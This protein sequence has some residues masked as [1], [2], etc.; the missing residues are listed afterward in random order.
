MEQELNQKDFNWVYYVVGLTSG[1]LTG[2][3]VEGHVIIGAILG[4][5]F[6]GLAKFAVNKSRE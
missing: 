3:A 6:G 2:F 4:L 5:L 1:I